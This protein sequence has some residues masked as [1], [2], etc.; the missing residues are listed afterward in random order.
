MTYAKIAKERDDLKSENETLR[1]IM[2]KML[3]KNK[4]LERENDELK[5]RLE[6]IEQKTRRTYERKIDPTNIPKHLHHRVWLILNDI[7]SPFFS[8]EDKAY[9]IRLMLDL[10]THNGITKDLILQWCDWLWNQSFN[11]KPKEDKND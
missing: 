2:D 10:T 7:N 4:A 6:R 5:V 8:D 11:L 3:E 9:C 1:A